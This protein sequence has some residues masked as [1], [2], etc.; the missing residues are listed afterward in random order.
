MFCITEKQQN[1]LFATFGKRKEKQKVL[2]DFFCLVPQASPAY[3]LSKYFLLT[4]S[5]KNTSQNTSIKNANLQTSKYP[6]FSPCI[7]TPRFL[8]S[9]FKNIK[10][11]QFPVTNFNRNKKNKIQ[12]IFWNFNNLPFPLGCVGIIRNELPRDYWANLSQEFP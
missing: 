12:F 1:P 4:P 5:I 9:K 2:S 8:S 6:A 10:Q 11:I 7:F 3:L